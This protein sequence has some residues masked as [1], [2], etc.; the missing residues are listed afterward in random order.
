M[1]N[2]QVNNYHNLKLE[3]NYDDYWDFY[4]NKDSLSRHDFNGRSLYDGCLIS[5]IDLCDEECKEADEWIYSKRGYYWQRAV[6]V[7]YE[8]YDISYTGV[9][10][11]LVRYRKDRISNKEFFCIFTNNTFDLFEDDYRLKLHA[12]SGNTLKY[13]Y[14][15]H[16][17]DCQVK[18]NGGFFQG[19]FK[20][21]CDIYQVLPSDFETGDV[22][23]FE[24]ELKRSD[25]EKESDKTLNDQYPDNKGFFF[26]LGA[27]AENKWIYLYD[28]ED[29]DGLESCFELGIGDFVDGGDID[30]KDYVIGSFDYPVI[31][32]DGYDPFELGDYTNYN[33][34]NEN[35]YRVDVDMDDFVELDYPVSPKIIDESK[36]HITLGWCCGNN[37]PDPAV[38]PFFRGCGCPFSYRGTSAGS[39][40]GVENCSAFG[41]DGYIGD[42]E[43][44]WPLSEEV[45]Y[46]EAELDIV[47][48]D[49]ETYEG[50][51]LSGANQ[52]YFYTDNKF[53]LFNRTKTGYTVNNWVDGTQ[54]LY[55]GQKSKFKGN[56]FLLMNR[57][58]TGYTV[59]TI[60]E[61]RRKDD[62]Y[63][64]PYKDVYDNALGFRITDDGEIGYRV[65]TVDCEKEGRDKTLM[66][67]GYSGKGVIPMDEWCVVNVK[68]NFS[69]GKM[70]LFFYVNGKLVYVSQDLPQIRMRELHDLWMKQEGVPFNISLGGGT[71]GLAETVQPNYMLEASRLYPLEKNF[72]GTFI[73]YIRAFRIYDCLME[74]G[75]IK[76]N[77]KYM[78]KNERSI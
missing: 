66:I 68:V 2:L 77:W 49:Y 9:D 29:V 58:K 60:D 59:D 72:A 47:D 55:Y 16:F 64:N 1:S 33:Y 50:I 53:L 43:D 11:G 41:E 75:N 40:A 4:V 17:E 31:D 71:Q 15:L 48:F 10:N 3:I 34:Y 8:M 52:Y 61:I 67:E 78:I 65:L 37:V 20:T 73:G 35:L 13:E 70:I 36:P 28:Q 27:R 39:S 26:Y 62:N 76:N 54:I 6:S 69:F 42:F 45:D 19:F 44:L 25:F 38:T 46:I 21:K 57:T 23:H 22:L 30:K 7:D 18:L 5:F 63:Y 74:H 51:S 24:F 12:V 14:P 56:L 32:W